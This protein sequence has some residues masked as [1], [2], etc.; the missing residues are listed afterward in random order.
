ML[1]FTKEWVESLAQ[2]LKN[3]AGYQEKA[4]GFDSSFQFVVKADPAKGVP[5]SRACG[6]T[7]PDCE[8]YWEG[9]REGTDY[10][11][12]GTYQVFYDILNGKMGATRAI[13][14]RKVR[15]KGNLAKLLKFNAAINR[16]VEVLGEVDTEYEGDYGK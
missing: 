12:S 5:E 3:D 2:I 11:M 10:T 1:A 15:L 6:V 14:T 4:R 8:E 9:I 16:F 7:L 13:T